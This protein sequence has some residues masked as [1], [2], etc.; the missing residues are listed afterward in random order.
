M[1]GKKIIKEHFTIL[2]YTILQKNTHTFWLYFT[3]LNETGQYLLFRDKR[4][5]LHLYEIVTQTK[6]TILNYCSYVQVCFVYISV[7][8]INKQC[9]QLFCISHPDPLTLLFSGY[10]AVML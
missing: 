9:V 3:Q 4:L 7:I 10:Q 2:L 6:Q 5:K 8:T 1:N